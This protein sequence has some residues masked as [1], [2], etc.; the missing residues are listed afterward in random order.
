MHLLVFCF[1]FVFY[2]I[3]CGGGLQKIIASKVRN[4]KYYTLKA[5]EADVHLLFDNAREYNLEGSQVYQVGGSMSTCSILKHILLL[6]GV[7]DVS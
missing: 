5:F 4:G 6:K 3:F 2:V 1:V 7:F